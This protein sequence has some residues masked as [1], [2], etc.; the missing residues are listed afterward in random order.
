MKFRFTHIA[1]IQTV[2]VCLALGALAPGQDAASFE[3]RTTVK[4]LANGLTVIICERPEAPVFSF[5]THVD[6]GSVQDPM[7]KTGL[8]HMFEH[9][10]FK[11]TNT[12]GTRDYAGE[13]VALEKVEVAYAA[14]IAERDKPVDRDEAKL[15]ELEQAWKDA[16]AAADKFSKP[17]NNEFG[18]IVESE[19]GE[20]MNA[21]TDYDETEYHY[22]FPVNRLELWAYLESERFIHP[23]LRQF[24]DERN[25]VIEERRMRVDSNPI[26]RLLEQFTEEAFAAHPYHR[27]TIG[28]ISDL[29]SFSA[30]DAQNFFDK[31]YVPSNMVVAV[32][33]DIKASDAMPIVE[34]YFS[35]IPARPKPDTA[36]T[37]EPPQNSER[38]VVLHEQAQPLY[39]EGY[40]RP[41]YRSPDDQVYDAIAD[42][43]SN[44]RTSRLYR[45]LV[46]D[47]QIASD[48]EGFT[49]LP[50]SKYPQLFAF[51]AFPIP[52]HTPKEMADAIHV[53]IDRLKKEDISDEELKMIKT[54]AKANLIRSLGSNEGLASELG[55]YQARYD[56][57]RELFRSVDR[58][59]RVTKADIRRVANETFTAEN[60][61]VGIIEFSGG[62]PGA[63]AGAGSAPPG[64]G[65]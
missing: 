63:G 55:I 26:G 1:A 32:V 31:Y 18:K 40:H 58:I 49:G 15:K 6:A 45:A 2:V 39:L 61:T 43:M 20:G 21:S 10:A 38:T 8:A 28:W 37:V 56:D 25:V 27:P 5:Y 36:T 52:G 19:G 60:R 29:N 12:I 50:G 17:Y 53:E 64:G 47:K 3:K 42:L 30:T 41:D 34:K 14:Y 65:Q 7:N 46:R 24:Y 59:E 16:V 48:S 23:V 4:K 57:W 11:G 44:G 9:M 35:R 62:P 13:K 22:A 54:R 33:G 51:Y